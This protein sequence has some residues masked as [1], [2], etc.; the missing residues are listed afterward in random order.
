MS[1][2]IYGKPG[3]AGSVFAKTTQTF[4]EVLSDPLTRALMA[5]DGVD[6]VAL[7][8]ELREIAE[9]LPGQESATENSCR[10]SC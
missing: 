5:A 3:A 8:A 10:G 1:R 7:E 6:A 9:K 2:I 4:P